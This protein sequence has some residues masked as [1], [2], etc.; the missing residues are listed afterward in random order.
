MLSMSTGSREM[1]RSAKLDYASVAFVDDNSTKLGQSI[2]G[3]PVLGNRT[4]IPRLVRELAITD[5]LIA[6]PFARG[7]EV[8]EI[9]EVCRNTA[10]GFKILPDLTRLQEG[11]FH[12][13]DLRQVQ[14][15]DLLGREPAEL[16]LNLISSYLRG[17]RVL[18]TG[19]G[20]SIGSELCRQILKFAPA[21]IHP[22]G[23]G[24][25]SIH[26]IHSELARRAGVSVL[27]I[28]VSRPNY[29]QHAFRGR[30][31]RQRERI[32]GENLKTAQ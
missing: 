24:E 27:T 25:N 28:E 30:L 16:D 5:I 12:V 26:E 17:K 22:L 2:H 18:V 31:A 19:A 23:R 20:G 10:A 9:V 14:V 4:D 11:K 32:R 13:S 1:M 15:E 3:V 21:E 29:L 6:I 8:R 7:R